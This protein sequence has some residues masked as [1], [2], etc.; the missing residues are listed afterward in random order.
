MSIAEVGN[1]TSASQPP[2]ID[3]TLAERGSRYGKFIDHA[4]ITQSLKY[5]MH[6]HKGWAN[7]DDD[8]REALDMVAHKIGSI[9][10][11]DP[12][13]ADSWHD[14]AGYAK[15]VDDRLNGESK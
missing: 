6:N 7:L 8:M 2:S 15:L 9:L 12:T 5:I 4:D 14:I 3:A 11:G 1:I 10:C 13:Y